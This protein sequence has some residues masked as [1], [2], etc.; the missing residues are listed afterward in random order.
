MGW[1]FRD[2]DKKFVVGIA[3]L[4]VFLFLGPTIASILASAFT[5]FAQSYYQ[6]LS[7]L[8][9]VYNSTTSQL[10]T[11]PFVDL[12][13]TFVAAN[14]TA[15]FILTLLTNRDAVLLLLGMSILLYIV[16]TVKTGR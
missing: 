2:V 11:E 9:D 12:S 10:G 16:T 8:Q 14:A 5:P 7:S 4:I 15:S 3:A 13:M 1:W 6:M